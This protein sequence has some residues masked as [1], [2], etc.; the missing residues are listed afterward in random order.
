M[1]SHPCVET[2]GGGVS[3]APTHASEPITLSPCQHLN[4]K[5]DRCRMFTSDLNSTLC[6]HHTRLRLKQQR[7]QH[8]ADAAELLGHL[9]D[10]STADSINA[11]L[12]NLVKQLARKRIA[13]RDAVALAYISQLLLNS[14]TA[15]DRQFDAERD[16]EGCRILDQYMRQSRANAASVS[17]E[18]ETA[19]QGVGA[20]KMR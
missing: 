16:A 12:G 8:D 15:L 3:L 9:T 20:D 6:P 7:R 4:A 11:F 18:S 14:L 17:A 2:T 19:A 5:G 13:R 10:F 1:K